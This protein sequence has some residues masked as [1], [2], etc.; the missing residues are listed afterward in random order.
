MFFTETIHLRQEKNSSLNDSRLTVW[1][2]SL[3]R[4]PL[5]RVPWNLN[6]RET[7]LYKWKTVTFSISSATILI[8]A[9]FCISV[10]LIFQ[11]SLCLLFESCLYISK[12]NI[13]QGYFRSPCRRTISTSITPL[14]T[15][16]LAIRFSFR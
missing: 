3:I 15:S 2:F 14:E 13:F 8:F 6:K 7:S 1:K 12:Q 11:I 5:L 4:R 16:A 10:A 9:H